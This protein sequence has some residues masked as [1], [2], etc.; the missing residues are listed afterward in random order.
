M[1]FI[2]QSRRLTPRFYAISATQ[3]NG[4]GNGFVA[5]YPEL[6][7]GDDLW[8]LREPKVGGH[9]DGG[10]F[11]TVGDHLEEQCLTRAREGPRGF[12]IHLM[13]KSSSRPLIRPNWVLNNPGTG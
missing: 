1:A 6:G 9:Y 7:I 10:L 5:R 2:D 4:S 13:P 8:P 3:P 11:G 12:W